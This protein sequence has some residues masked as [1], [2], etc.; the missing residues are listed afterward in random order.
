MLLNPAVVVEVLSEST[1]SR[2]EGIKKH[3]YLAMDS[4][5]Q[6]ILVDSEAMQVSTYTRQNARAWTFRQ[7]RA[8]EEYVLVRECRLLLRDMYRNVEGV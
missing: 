2:D 3:C 4:V 6:Y 5:E 1:R 8:P 7:F